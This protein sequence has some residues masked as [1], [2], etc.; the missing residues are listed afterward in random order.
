MYKILLLLIVILIATFF[1]IWKLD[2]PDVTPDEN[3]YITDAFRLYNKDPYISIRHHPF[4][5]PT[6]SIGH[7]FLAQVVT[8]SVFILF[9]S[10]IFTSRLAV[11]LAG[12]LT[13]VI[14]LFF[15]DR[16]GRWIALYAAILFSVSPFAVRYNRN[17]H[18]DSLFAFL[19]TLT[20]LLMWKYLNANNK[21][22]LLFAGLVSG[23]AFSVKLNGVLSIALIFGLL[24]VVKKGGLFTKKDF[25]TT[26]LE[27]L[28]ISVPFAAVSYLLNDPL[29]YLDGIVNPSFTGWRF[30]S[31]DFWMTRIT[32]MSVPNL[33]A[34]LFYLLSPGMLVAY[35]YSLFYIIFRDSG[36]IKRL[37]LS[38]Q[39][40]LFP[41][42]L[43]HGFTIDGSYGWLPL[44]VPI[45]F[46]VSYAMH[47]SKLKPIAYLA[48]AVTI[49]PFTVLYGLR[50]AVLP[51]SGVLY[52]P[53]YNRTIGNNYYAN[54]IDVVNKY[55]PQKA[56]VLLLPQ[57]NYPLFSLRKDFHWSYDANQS[58]YDLFVVDD[59][60]L[61]EGL[62]Y[63]VNLIQTLEAFQ[64][65]SKIKRFI[66][67][68]AH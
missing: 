54:V 27:I 42:V 30:T 67:L 22:W 33:L 11:A 1:R 35:L 52:S 37:L 21:I 7:P 44:A 47:K 45:V 34:S 28:F 39:I 2:A 5:H 53:V 56:N 50:F 15:H 41:L 49:L 66:F 3:H 19:L 18:P 16:L 63:K 24:L 48:L 20:V 12:I 68:R 61:V 65:G 31:I 23:L 40:I 59:K 38:W 4:K 8:A 51:T 14:I 29:A 62:G 25:K 60:E 6:P 13:A 36:Q 43:I 26:I 57:G 46:S 9:D 55:A 32:L 64:D 17:A 10:T 58:N